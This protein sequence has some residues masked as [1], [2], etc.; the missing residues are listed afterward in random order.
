F[1]AVR[2]SS[3]GQIVLFA[4]ALTVLPPAVLLGAEVLVGLVSRTAAG[5]LHLFF[6]AGLV[7]VIVL[8]A[9]TKA[10][11]VSGLAALVAAA[12]AGVGVAALYSRVQAVQTFL[13]VLVAAPVVFLVLFLFNSPVSKLVRPESAQATIVAVRSPTP[14]V[15]V[16]FDEF[17]TVALM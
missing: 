11:A 16:V 10:A 1:F 15:L 3:A 8:H 17:P 13:T 4:L 5:V 6:V 12:L 7:A 2:D 14:V 9:L